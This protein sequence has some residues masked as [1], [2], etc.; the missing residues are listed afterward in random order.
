VNPQQNPIPNWPFTRLPVAPKAERNAPPADMPAAPFVLAGVAFVA[1]LA[2]PMPAF[3]QTVA[4]P[5]S[6]VPVVPTVNATTAVSNV[7]T[8][9]N[10]NNSVN[11][12]I[13]NSRGS[14]TTLTGGNSA[15]N[16]AGGDATGGS[17]S[18][19]TGNSTGTGYGGAGG[20][21]GVGGAGGQGVGGTGAGGTG[22]AASNSFTDASS[23]S[24][25]YRNLNLWL[26]SPL[27]VPQPAAPTAA[28]VIS[29]ATGFAI[30]FNFLSTTGAAQ[31]IDPLCMAERQAAALEARCKFRSATAMREWIAREV[32][33]ATPG[34]SDFMALTGA[35]AYQR[36]RDLTVEE[37]AALTGASK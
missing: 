1:A 28:C 34:L 8:N 13:N 12:N 14:D 32:T 19:R 29:N 24:A 22:G 5:S 30:G 4:K 3:S 11:T 36:E 17:A 15:S 10:T 9:V 26:P 25:S 6:P 7:N 2:L 33:K 16:S 27:N 37:C 23:Q 31:T 35:A 21:G 20:Q 18:A